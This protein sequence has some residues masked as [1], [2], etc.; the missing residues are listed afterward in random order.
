MTI[1]PFVGAGL[2]A[3]YYQFRSSGARKVEQNISL[4]VGHHDPQLPVMFPHLPL[5]SAPTP[6]SAL[7]DGRRVQLVYAFVRLRSVCVRCPHS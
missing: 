7:A 1:A 6:I 2:A 3:A 4:P 5:P